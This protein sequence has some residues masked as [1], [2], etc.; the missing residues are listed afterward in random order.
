MKKLLGLVF[1]VG[2]LSC[3]THRER[4]FFSDPLL[5]TIPDSISYP[6]D[7]KDHLQGMATDYENYLFWSQT[8][9]LVKSDLQG[10]ILKSINVPTHHGDLAYQDHKLYVAV[11]LGKFN[12]LPGLADSWVYVYDADDLS[13]IKKYPVPEVV[14]GAGGIVI[15][16]GRVMVVGGLPNLPGYTN[17]FVYE[18][19]LDFNWR[20]THVLESGY[21]RLGIQTAAW[22]DGCWYFGCYDSDQHPKGLV[23][24]VAESDNGDLLLADTFNLDMTYGLIGLRGKK[25]LASCKAFNHKAAIVE[26]GH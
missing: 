10:R 21:T 14:H 17:N 8:T 2:L 11:N 19:D 12:E 4:S 26:L 16:K 23:L 20:Q 9:V 22:F 3:A 24:K 7:Y 6:S 1:I 5:A 25:F 13:F 18:Y 15:H